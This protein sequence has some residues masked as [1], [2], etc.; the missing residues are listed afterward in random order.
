M[1]EVNRHGKGELDVLNSYAETQKRDR[2]YRDSN[3]TPVFNSR[4]GAVET[5]DKPAGTPV[6]KP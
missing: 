6:S 5:S 3:A 1:D 2:I 4:G